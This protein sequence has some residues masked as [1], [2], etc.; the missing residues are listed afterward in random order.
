MK[1]D[2]RQLPPSFRQ[3]VDVAATKLAGPVGMVELYTEVPRVLYAGT[4]LYHGTF[5]VALYD[6][7]HVPGMLGTLGTG[8]MMIGST[9]RSMFGVLVA[10][11]G[12]HSMPEI[13]FVH[14]YARTH[15]PSYRFAVPIYQYQR[16]LWSGH[17]KLAREL[18]FTLYI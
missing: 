13:C 11:Y 6:H 14:W 12:H 18:C 7:Q 4:R 16:C 3:A 15:S 9:I 2:S 10:R 5:G 8:I 1:A 17:Y